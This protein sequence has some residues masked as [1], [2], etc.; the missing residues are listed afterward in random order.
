MARR[1]TGDRRLDV[2][3]RDGDRYRPDPDAF[4]VDLWRSE[5]CLADAKRAADAHDADAENGAAHG[6]GG[7]LRRRAPGRQPGRLGDHPARGPSAFRDPDS[8]QWELFERP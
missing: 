8:I 3:R 5:S 6:G 7:R 2:I 1:A 4:D